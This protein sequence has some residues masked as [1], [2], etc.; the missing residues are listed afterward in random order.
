MSTEQSPDAENNAPA[1]AGDVPPPPPSAPAETPPPA[2]ADAPPP[3]PSYTA[4]AAAPASATEAKD[5]KI[6]AGILGIVLGCFGVH[7]FVLGYKNEGI[8]MC[9]V[10]VLGY[11]LCAIPTLVMAI[12]GLIEGII[13]LTKTDEEF[14]RIYI[15]GRKPWF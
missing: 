2:P 6:L 3:A 8:I 7:K 14:G 11:F 13:Y 9:V 15:Q 1:P 5:K 12:I 10:G 4:P